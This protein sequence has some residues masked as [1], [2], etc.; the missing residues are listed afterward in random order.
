M[1]AQEYIDKKLADLAEKPDLLNSNEDKPLEERIYKSLTSK[2]FR[3]Y[4]MNQ[5]LEDHVRSAIKLSVDQSQPIKLVFLQGAYKLWRLEGS[6]NA[7]WAELFALMRYVNWTKSVCKFYEPGVEFD[8]FL[9]DLIV[10]MSNGIEAKEVD[11][12]IFSLN[13]LIKFISQFT[14]D[15]MKITTTTVGSLFSSKEDF[16]DKVL[17]ESRKIKE[18][19]GGF[20][21]LDQAKKTSIELNSRPTSEQSNNPNWREESWLLHEGYSAV[22]GSTGYHNQV[23]KIMVFPAHL[24][25]AI[26]VGTTSRSIMKHWIGVGCLIKSKDGFYQEVLSP[27]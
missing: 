9:D 26:C 24:S 19:R 16:E 20:A 3:K 6:P 12:Y 1:T 22:K 7:D 4:S 2:K 14:S 15:N 13:E 27:A 11:D 21:E 17:E 25:K 10:P 5:E 8:F 18:S 23:D